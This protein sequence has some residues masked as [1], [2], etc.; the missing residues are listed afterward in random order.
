VGTYLQNILSRH[1]A[2]A[3]CDEGT[4]EGAEAIVGCRSIALQQ[5]DMRLVSQDRLTNKWGWTDREYESLEIV[6]D[7]QLERVGLIIDPMRPKKPK[8]WKIFGPDEI[9]LNAHPE[10]IRRR[11]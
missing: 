5:P 6:L 2:Q 7:E 3:L 1:S 10:S 11:C 9:S 8:S 4:G